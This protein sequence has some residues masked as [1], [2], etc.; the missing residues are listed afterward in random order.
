MLAWYCASHLRIASLG[1]FNT[2][3][4]ARW[5]TMSDF[6]QK[7]SRSSTNPKPQKREYSA[8]TLACTKQ[9]LPLYKVSSLRAYIFRS[10]VSMS[11]NIAEKFNPTI[12][13]HVSAGF[14]MWIVSS[15]SWKIFLEFFFSRMVLVGLHHWSPDLQMPVANI[16][17]TTFT[18]QKV[19]I[20]N[21]TA[22]K[23]IISPN[24]RS[25]H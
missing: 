6:P 16:K 20:S 22:P 1:D 9:E 13:I 11:A 25:L 2:V 12:C 10:H 15:Y 7:I 23:S 19:L 24:F 21:G 18:N 4:S 14:L 8:A 17:P 5:I 3:L